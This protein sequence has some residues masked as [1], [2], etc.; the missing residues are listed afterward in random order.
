MVF[1]LGGSPSRLGNMG[2]GKRPQP[3]PTSRSLA[4][5]VLTNFPGASD[6]LRSW[7]PLLL[8]I[9]PGI[10]GVHACGGWNLVSSVSSPGKAAD[11]KCGRR[12][13]RGRCLG[14]ELSPGPHLEARKGVA[15]RSRDSAQQTSTDQHVTQQ[16]VGRA[17]ESSVSV[18]VIGSHSL[19][20]SLGG[21]FK[22][23]LPEEVTFKPD[24]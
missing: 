5:C 4:L 10:T 16:P 23:G 19:L 18:P 12:P 8:G 15:S 20:A 2:K 14:E 24:A 6:P 11:R 21:V 13:E 9:M 7:K 22:E 17:V 3:C 1:E